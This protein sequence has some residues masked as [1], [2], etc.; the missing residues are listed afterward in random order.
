MQVAG[1]GAATVTWQGLETL[2][3]A[4]S[5][6]WVKVPRLAL[7]QIVAWTTLRIGDGTL[8]AENSALSAGKVQCLVGDVNRNSDLL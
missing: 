4:G 1:L 7:I 3:A 2:Q 5:G 6:F 8:Q